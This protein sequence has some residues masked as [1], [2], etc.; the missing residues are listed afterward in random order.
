MELEVGKRYLMRLESKYNSVVSEVTVVEISPSGAYAKL[1]V[2][3]AESVV[4][5]WYETAQ[6]R[7]VEAL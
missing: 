4:N 5:H 7:V 3:N 6:V 1:R 2:Y